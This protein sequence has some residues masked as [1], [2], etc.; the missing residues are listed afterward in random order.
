M[1]S[2]DT[3]TNNTYTLLSNRLEALKLTSSSFP[4]NLTVLSDARGECCGYATSS[5]NKV[6][7]IRWR[8]GIYSQTIVEPFSC[9]MDDEMESVDGLTLVNGVKWCYLLS[10]ETVLVVTSFAGFAVSCVVSMVTKHRS[11]LFLYQIYNTDGSLKIFQYRITHNDQLKG[12][13]YC[14]HLYNLMI[15][16]FEVL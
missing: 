3:A 9:S 1:A 7:V 5:G 12:E 10:G 4:S 11:I 16:V 14:M 6:I 2:H 8:N 15:C 13:L